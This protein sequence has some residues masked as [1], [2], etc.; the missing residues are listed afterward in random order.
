M[1]RQLLSDKEAEYADL[2]KRYAELQ[3]S[4][5]QSSARRADSSGSGASGSTRRGGGPGFSRVQGNAWLERMRQEDPQRYQQFVA[6]R[7][8][9]RQQAAQ[10]FQ[11][12][13]TQLNVRAQNAPTQQE[14]DLATQITDTLT[15]LNDLRTQ[16]DAARNLPEDDPQRETQMQQLRSEMRESFQQLGQLREQDRAQQLQALAEQLGLKD[17]SAQTLV[18]SVP[19]IYQNTR[20]GPGAGPGG[21]G[22]GP[23]GPGGPPPSPPEASASSQ[24]QQQSQQ[25]P[26]R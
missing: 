7:E 14:A 18:E 3:R 4:V 11:D 10:A 21:R 1:L 12:E 25:P 2:Q 16:M 8:Q 23:E 24:Q 17:D 26:A 22:G 5:G 9:R 13:L 15:K 19:Q 6:Q 20:Y